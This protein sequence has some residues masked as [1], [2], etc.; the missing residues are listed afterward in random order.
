[1][2]VFANQDLLSQ[3]ERDLSPSLA[4]SGFWL[5][6]V[7]P[8]LRAVLWTNGPTQGAYLGKD[9]SNGNFREMV[10]IHTTML[11]REGVQKK[12]VFFM[13][14]CQTPPRT[15]PPPVWSFYG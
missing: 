9:S 12:N 11:V 2:R 7:S 4:V 14:F 5:F 10:E 1:M 3:R 13:V 8:N 15:P 6:P